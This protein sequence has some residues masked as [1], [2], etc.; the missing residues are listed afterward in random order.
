MVVTILDWRDP[1]VGD[2]D[3]DRFD[4]ASSTPSAG[5]GTRCR[6]WSIF[7]DRYMKRLVTIGRDAHNQLIAT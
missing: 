2:V 5:D 4:G 1:S 6:R 3:D 7:D